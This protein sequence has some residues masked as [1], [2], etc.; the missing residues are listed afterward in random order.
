MSDVQ[1][2]V[3]TRFNLPTAG[4]ES[5]VRASD[6][7][8]RNRNR[9]FERYCVPSV[10]AQS[11]QDFKWIIYFDPDSPTWLQS[12]I[13]SAVDDGTYTA[14]FRRAVSRT[15]LL[16]DIRAISDPTRSTLL[17]T[18]LDND[19]GLAIDF[20]ERLQ[21]ARPAAKRTAL[22]MTRG[23]IRSDEQLYLRTDPANAFCSV[24]EPADDPVTAWAD[25]HN[26]LGRTMPVEEINESPTWLQ[27][28]HGQNVSNRARGIRVSPTPYRE[29]FAGLLDDV[30]DPTMG[31]ILR[32]RII[33]RTQRALGETT[34]TAA[35][36][37]TLALVGKD[38]LDKVKHAIK[39]RRKR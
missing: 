1:H 18:N 8:L 21:N 13:K 35:K 30:P 9:L 6:G 15:E 11:C 12:K 37:I 29:R 33:D 38:G 39:T 32:D 17:T 2:V 4:V 10:R 5:L 28:V 7:W 3:L 14:I 34:R 31:E 36:T 26:R 19:D 23:L 24:R 20:V 27:V 25:W 16:S 22:Y